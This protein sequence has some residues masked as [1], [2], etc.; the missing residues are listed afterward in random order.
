[1]N[2]YTK[3]TYDT[4]A[5]TV[6]GSV[7]ELADKL[8]EKQ[9]KATLRLGIINDKEHEK[10]NLDVLSELQTAGLKQRKDYMIARLPAVMK[11]FY[12]TPILWTSEEN[13]W[14]H[15]K[16]TFSGYEEILYFI[17]EITR[18]I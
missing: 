1:M 5:V 15:R 8:T 12:P 6:A 10:Q 13:P 4:S 9:P 3:I 17:K 2:K 11:N 7:K 16:E 18:K 14:T